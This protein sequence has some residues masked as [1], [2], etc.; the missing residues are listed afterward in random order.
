MNPLFSE[1]FKRRSVRKFSSA[2]LDK[3]IVKELLEA[4][5]AAPSARCMDPW[6]FTCFNGDFCQ[7]VV[8]AL[9]NGQVLV[10]ANNGVL[11]CADMDRV[12]D[13]EL[14]FALQDCSAAIENFLIATSMKGLGA[15]WMGVHPREERIEAM[16]KIFKLPDHLLPVA[17][18]AFGE[19][20][21]H[22]ENRTRYDE[23]KVVWL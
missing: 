10:S 19:S 7:D 16:K 4:A 14:S 15:C 6:H 17:V 22:H 13:G 3:E 5:M 8:P 11:I 21:E 12:Y 1:L 18:I 2:I 23:E 20:T 9:S